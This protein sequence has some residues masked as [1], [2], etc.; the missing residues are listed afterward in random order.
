MRN[1]G[2]WWWDRIWNPTG[3]CYPVCPGCADCEAAEVIGTY[4]WDSPTIHDGLTRAKG[5]RRFWTG[6]VASLPDGDDSW[7]LPLVWPGAKHPKLGK[8]K[9]SLLAVF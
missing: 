8:G 1:F 4:T 7:L 6:D 2:G 3:G 5:K 9:P